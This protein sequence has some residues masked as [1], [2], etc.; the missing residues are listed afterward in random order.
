M[1]GRRTKVASVPETSSAGTNTSGFRFTSTDTPAATGTFPPYL[2][3]P[4]FS[5]SRM[6]AATTGS[7]IS[8][9]P[10]WMQ[11]DKSSHK[12]TTSDLSSPHA[13]MQ[14]WGNGTHPPGGFMSFFHNQPNI[15]Q[16]YNFVGASSHYTPLHANGS[17]P[18]LANG[19]SM[20]LATPTPPPLTGN[21]DH[22]N[23]DSDDDTAVARTKLKLNWTQEEDVRPMSAWLNNSMD[24][25][26]GNDK[27]AEKYWGDVATEYNKTTP[28]NRWR[29]PKQAKERWHKLN[30]R[31]DLF[32]GCW[33]KAKRTYTSGYSELNVD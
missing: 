4:P 12:A 23:V 13:N 9:S 32:Q 3:I 28:Q 17:S 1:A 31:T 25:I 22:V 5:A 30:T 19:A 10:S 21:Q 26:N 18:P 16:H 11:T 20:P 14:S 15:S 24:L 33:L 27:K 7:H 2:G 6:S 29:S 8:P